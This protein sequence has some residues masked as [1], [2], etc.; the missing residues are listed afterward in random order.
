MCRPAQVVTGDLSDAG[1]TFN[2]LLTS[3]ALLFFGLAD[4]LYAASICLFLFQ[5]YPQTAPSS[6]ASSHTCQMHACISCDRL[7][8]F[9]LHCLTRQVGR[10]P[11]NECTCAEGDR[12]RLVQR[13]D[14]NRAPPNTAAVAGRSMAEIPMWHEPI[15]ELR[16]SRSALEHVSPLDARQFDEARREFEQ[17][18]SRVEAQTGQRFLHCSKHMRNS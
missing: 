4:E 17:R 15:P 7:R 2:G 18:V 16:V 9:Q 11:R 5:A 1:L 6:R 8:W 14:R 13:F 12:A 3:G 10:F